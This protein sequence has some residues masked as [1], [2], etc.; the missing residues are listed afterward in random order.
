MAVRVRADGRIV[1][2]AMHPAEP[3]DDYLPDNVTQHLTG[4]TGMTPVLVTE[5]WEVPAGRGSGG[6]S[7]HG[8]WWWA[9]DVPDD[10][11]IV[12]WWLQPPRPTSTL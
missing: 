1:C 7:V 4:S 8:E 3:G 10:V 9:N 11:L 6:H 12:D 5:P 2:A